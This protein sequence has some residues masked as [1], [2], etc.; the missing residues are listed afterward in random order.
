MLQQAW[1]SMC[2]YNKALLVQ[3][4]LADGLNYVA[5]F[6]AFLPAYFANARANVNVGIAR[7]LLL[8]VDLI[9]LLHAQLT[10]DKLDHNAIKVDLSELAAVTKDAACSRDFDLMTERM[11]IVSKGNDMMVQVQTAIVVDEKLE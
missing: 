10:L 5:F 9:S 4:F 11:Q 6:F 2:K 8:L 3:H 7:A 1:E